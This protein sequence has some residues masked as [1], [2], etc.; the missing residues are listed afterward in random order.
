VELENG[1]SR[2]VL[3]ISSEVLAK[4]EEDG[5]DQPNKRGDLIAK[6]D[7]AN[8]KV[9]LLKTGITATNSLLAVA[10]R[11]HPESSEKPHILGFGAHGLT[12]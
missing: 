11:F 5:V 12:S 9:P 1:W 8:F 7:S 4:L 10:Q 6:L 3:F 2:G